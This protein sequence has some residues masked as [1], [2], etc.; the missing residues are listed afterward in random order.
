MD[1]MPTCY[2]HGGPWDDGEDSQGRFIANPG[3]I[4]VTPCGHTYLWASSG[5]EFTRNNEKW[6]D[7]VEPYVSSY[8]SPNPKQLQRFLDHAAQRLID[9]TRVQTNDPRA[10]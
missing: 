1:P 9:S 5:G 8:G 4:I 6:G 7:L 10:R 3:R 2:F